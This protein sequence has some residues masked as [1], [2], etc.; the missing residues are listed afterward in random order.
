MGVLQMDGLLVEIED[1][2]GYSHLPKPPS[3][4]EDGSLRRSRTRGAA[5]CHEGPGSRAEFGGFRL[6]GGRA[7]KGKNLE[8]HRISMNFTDTMI[9]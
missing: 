9:H 1:D 6:R 5:E 8:I 3:G 7:P 2:W 4:E